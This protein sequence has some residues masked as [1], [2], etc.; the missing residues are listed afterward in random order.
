[1]ESKDVHSNELLQVVGV[2]EQGHL[3]ARF[4]YELGRTVLAEGKESFEVAIATLYIELRHAKAA[5]TQAET[6]AAR[7][8]Q[9]LAAVDHRE[10]MNTALAASNH[11]MCPLRQNVCRLREELLASHQDSLTAGQDARRLRA[12]W[13]E[14]CVSLQELVGGQQNHASA[15]ASVRFT[16]LLNHRLQGRDS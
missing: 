13:A 3:L 15:R 1:M 10:T 12:R 16:T 5:R 11:K 8:E 4:S 2:A 9:R 14:A 7:V 6:L